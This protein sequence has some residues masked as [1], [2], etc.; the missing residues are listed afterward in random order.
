MEGIYTA[1]ISGVEGNGFGMLVFK[2][3]LITGADA[4]GVNFDGEYSFD[5][6]KKKYEGEIKVT[7]PPNSILIQGQNTGPN[8]MEYKFEISLSEN[9]LE[10]PFITIVTP[11]GPINIILEKL[12]EL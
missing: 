12:R 8:G 4:A 10:E 9:F 2:N 1:Y 11:L 3:G 7:A 6:K 5:I